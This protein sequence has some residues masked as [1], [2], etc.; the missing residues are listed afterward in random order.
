MRYVGQAYELTIPVSDSVEVSEM[1]DRFAEEHR[2]TY[3]HASSDPVQVVSIRIT[4][5][6]A[7]PY[8]TLAGLHT[9]NDSAI[10]SQERPVFFGN[11][12]QLVTP[13]VSRSSLEG[14]AVDGPL[15]IEEYDATCVIP[16]GWTA[17]LDQF[18]NIHLRADH[19]TS[20]A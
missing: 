18:Q 8:A 13:V 19:L 5:R 14:A 10:K 7:N 3:G 4:F 15:I 12:G 17:S 20:G 9:D 1:I 6:N 2:A 16:P 11:D